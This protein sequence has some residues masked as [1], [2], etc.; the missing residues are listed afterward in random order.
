M[1]FAPKQPLLTMTMIGF[2]RDTNIQ[3]NGGA[4][5]LV[6]SNYTSLLLI[7]VNK[8]SL[9]LNLI[10]HGKYYRCHLSIR[11]ATALQSN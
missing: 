3:Q 11:P 5:M 2:P 6:S 4:R 1:H 10:P 8:M 9:I 7:I